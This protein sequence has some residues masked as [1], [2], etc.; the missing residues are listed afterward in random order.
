MGGTVTLIPSPLSACVVLSAAAA[1]VGVGALVGGWGGR[2]AVLD[3][4]RRLL[5]YE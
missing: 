2:G 4:Y 3:T 1:R 5:L